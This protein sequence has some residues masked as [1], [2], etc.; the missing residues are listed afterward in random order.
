MGRRQL[1]QTKWYK[2]FEPVFVAAL[3]VRF[4]LVL[5]NETVPSAEEFVRVI[6]AT[7]LHRK[8]LAPLAQVVEA[9][10]R[11]ALGSNDRSPSD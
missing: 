11:R 2:K 3:E 1:Y 8:N 4:Q 5:L 10:D 6:L 7:N 9:V